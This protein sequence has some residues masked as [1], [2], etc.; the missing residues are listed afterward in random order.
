[1]DIIEEI[2]QRGPYSL[3]GAAETLSP[4]THRSAGALFLVRVRD[5]LLEEIEWRVNN[6][7]TVLDAA[8]DFVDND[9]YG[10]VADQAPSVYTHELWSQFADLGGYREDLSDHDL[11]VDE[12]DKIPS[13]ALYLIAWRLAEV[14]TEEII[15]VIENEEN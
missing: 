10:V 7:W 4:D 5:S 6:G 2:K 14:L 9:G 11:N 1:M 8:K 3:A 15:D 13:L 12:L